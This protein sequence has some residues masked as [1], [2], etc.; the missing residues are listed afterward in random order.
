MWGESH[1]E[2]VLQPI[3]MHKLRRVTHRFQQGVH[4]VGI[5]E[6]GAADTCREGVLFP[7]S[8]QTRHYQCTFSICKILCC[9]SQ[10][11]NHTHT[12]R[13]ADKYIQTYLT[14]ASSASQPSPITNTQA[15]SQTTEPV[16]DAQSPQPVVLGLQLAHCRFNDRV[17]TNR[18]V[19]SQKIQ[20]AGADR[21]GG[22]KL[23][24]PPRYTDDS[25]KM[26]NK[27]GLLNDERMDSDT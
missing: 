4:Q 21:D 12:P 1:R 26:Y 14:W 7:S 24:R 22:P 3:Q 19:S 11:Y 20:A 2:T 23:K 27:Y 16:S 8:P 10:D 5:G 15:E 9:N 6:E 17:L 25:L 18:E 13:T